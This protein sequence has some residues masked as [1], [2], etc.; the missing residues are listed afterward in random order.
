M[1]NDEDDGEN[2]SH[3]RFNRTMNLPTSAPE[4]YP[5]IC[6]YKPL[7]HLQMIYIN[8]IEVNEKRRGITKKV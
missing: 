7:I 8:K 3:L 5:Q 4:G 6:R 2:C 1:E